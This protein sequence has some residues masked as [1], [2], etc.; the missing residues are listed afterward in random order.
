[1]SS[2]LD[3]EGIGFNKES[4]PVIEI[5]DEMLFWTKGLLHLNCYSILCGAKWSLMEFNI[6]NK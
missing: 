1:M 4:T 3:R 6:I 2:S 5:E